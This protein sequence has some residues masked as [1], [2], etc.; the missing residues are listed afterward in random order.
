M[1]AVCQ[2]FVEKMQYAPGERDMLVM[3]HTFV[4]EYADRRETLTSTL[5][6]FGIKVI[7]IS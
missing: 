5:V 4:A 6:D 3:Q 1:D 7:F 2:L